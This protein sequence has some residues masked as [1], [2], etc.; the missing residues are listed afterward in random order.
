MYVPLN[1]MPPLEIPDHIPETFW[2]DR[3]DV[4]EKMVHDEETNVDIAI[5]MA[6]LDDEVKDHFHP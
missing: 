4:V 3:L 5:A 2:I 6:R 1:L